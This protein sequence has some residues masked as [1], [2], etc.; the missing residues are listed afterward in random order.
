MIILRSATLRMRKT[1]PRNRI[2]ARQIIKRAELGPLP[3]VIVTHDDVVDPAALVELG[4]SRNEY[5][6]RLSDYQELHSLLNYLLPVLP[7]D[8][9]AERAYS[10]SEPVGLP[11]LA[12][13]APAPHLRRDDEPDSR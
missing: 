13:S 7:A 6:T 12:T 10:A 2:L 9:G 5:V 3:A 1:R 8:D 4:P 11:L